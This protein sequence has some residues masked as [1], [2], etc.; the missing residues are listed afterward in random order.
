MEGGTLIKDNIIKKIIDKQRSGKYRIV[1]LLASGFWDSDRINRI[2]VKLVYFGLARDKIKPA[3][4][5]QP[6]SNL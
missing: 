3:Q 2:L 1:W 6:D 4:I 5:F